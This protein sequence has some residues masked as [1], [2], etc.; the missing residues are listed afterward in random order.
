MKYFLISFFLIPTLIFGQSSQSLKVKLIDYSSDKIPAYC[1]YIAFATTLKFE[2]VDNYDTLK[3][4]KEILL[5]IT[6]PREIGIENYVNNQVYTLT[7]YGDS[8]EDRKH[9]NYGW[10]IW[11]KYDNEKLP[12]FWSKELKKI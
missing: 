7:I 3:K 9:K 11:Y 1:G 6:C 5:I 8:E 12:T 10:S 4:G 2:L